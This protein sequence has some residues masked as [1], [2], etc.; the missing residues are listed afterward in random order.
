MKPRKETTMNETSKRA[1]LGRYFAR[2]HVGAVRS[3]FCTGYVA[4]VWAL[5][6]WFVQTLV[7]PG[8]FTR[9]R[10][11]VMG[12]PIPAYSRLTAHQ[13][14]AGFLDIVFV[15]A[16]LLLGQFVATLYFYRR[17]QIEGK[18][19]ARPTLWPVSAIATA[20]LGNAIWEIV[21]PNGLDFEGFLVGLMPALVTLAIEHILEALGRD[22]VRGTATGFHPA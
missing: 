22:F 15:L 7:F 18:A 16:A 20:L 6:P 11:F 21:L 5:I 1:A 4:L 14:T 8:D 17:A 19:A 2:V 9:F 3:P 12:L 10:A 13:I